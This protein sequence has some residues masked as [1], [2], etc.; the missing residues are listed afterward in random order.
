MNIDLAHRLKSALTAR[1]EELFASCGDAA[2][3]VL[4][5]LLRNPALA[6]NHLL[7]LLERRE[8]PEELLAAISRHPLAGESHRV[9]VA[10]VHHPNTPGPQLLALLP[11]LYLFELVTVCYLPGTTPDQRVAAE[12]AIIQRLPTTQLGN[13]LT[14]ARRGTGAIVEAL[15][16]E[17]DPR[18]LAACLDNPHLKEGMVFQFLSGRWATA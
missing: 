4:Q 15:L 11:H 16:K 10:L 5:A 13:K 14:L 7:A 18:L 3:E 1:G 17:A 8:L 6:E 2:P 12:R 9:K